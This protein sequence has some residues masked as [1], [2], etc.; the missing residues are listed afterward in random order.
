MF[1]FLMHGKCGLEAELS[2]PNHL[3]TLPV[4]SMFHHQAGAHFISRQ[5]WQVSA[6]SL[7]VVICILTPELTGEVRFASKRQRK[8]L[9]DLFPG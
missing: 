9:P 6:G 1:I 8:L 2:D 4:A 7:L 3:Q 5:G